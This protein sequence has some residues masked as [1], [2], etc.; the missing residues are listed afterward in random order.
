MLAGA[1]GAA[2]QNH[3]CTLPPRESQS[4]AAELLPLPNHKGARGDEPGT[5]AATL[6]LAPKKPGLL[7]HWHRHHRYLC[8]HPNS[9]GGGALQSK[10]SASLPGQRATS[11]RPLPNS[12][13]PRQRGR[14]AASRAPCRNAASPG[15]GRGVA[16]A[17]QNLPSRGC[18]KSLCRDRRNRSTFTDNVQTSAKLSAAALSPKSGLL[19]KSTRRTPAN[20]LSSSP[21]LAECSTDRGQLLPRGAEQDEAPTGARGSASETRAPSGTPKCHNAGTKSSFLGIRQLRLLKTSG[22]GSFLNSPSPRSQTGL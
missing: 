14:D 21:R 2:E 19:Q 20:H 5:R 6:F 7:R 13:P 18:Q 10:P 15:R 9:S 1:V 12:Q 8:H 16:R 17:P 4:L 11:K 3:L 22:T